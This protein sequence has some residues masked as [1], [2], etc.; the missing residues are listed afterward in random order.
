MEPTAPKTWDRVG[1]NTW[2]TT[3]TSDPSRSLL[4][5]LVDPASARNRVRLGQDSWSTPEQFRLGTES[6]GTPGPPHSSSDPGPS[7]LGQLVDP[8]SARTRDLVGRD[9]WWTP[10]HLEPRSE[11]DSWSTLRQL[12]PGTESAGIAGRPTA[13]RTLIRGGWDS[14]STPPP[15]GL[16]DP[17][18]SR[19][20]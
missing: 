17:G 4:G 18:P 14:W 12:R 7:R 19:P 5:Q 16:S 10:Q 20:G 11:L 8:A 2:S 3:Q 9:S 13:P 6:A 15:L 1:R